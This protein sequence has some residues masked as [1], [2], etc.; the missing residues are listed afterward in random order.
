[1]PIRSLH[2]FIAGCLFGFVGLLGTAAIAS[3]PNAKLP[4]PITLASRLTLQGSEASP[5]TVQP[6][7]LPSSLTNPI[8]ILPLATGGPFVFE[9]LPT[10]GS[11]VL[12]PNVHCTGP[13]YRGCSPRIYYGTNPCDD[14]P[15]LTM[16]PDVCDAKTTHWYTKAWNMISRKKAIAEAVS[17]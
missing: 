16:S 7:D 4:Q 13:D 2:L 1:M 11:C 10:P 6:A 3:E 5:T 17:P 8:G 9:P 15:I 14:D 12:R